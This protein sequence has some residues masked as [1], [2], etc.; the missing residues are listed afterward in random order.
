MDF[1]MWQERSAEC[2]LGDQNMFIDI[3][4]DISPGMLWL[5]DEDIP[6]GISHTTSSPIGVIRSVP[7]CPWCHRLPYL[8]SYPILYYN[9]AVMSRDCCGL[10]LVPEPSSVRFCRGVPPANT[11]LRS[12]SGAPRR[13]HRCRDSTPHR[14]HTWRTAAGPKKRR[15]RPLAS[16]GGGRRHLLK[17]LTRY[18]TI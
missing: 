16:A 3:S 12:R 17:V 1:L 13:S 6:S 14:H 11:D 5:S 2:R 10:R 7:T 9:V 15:Q 8:L 4:S 18:V